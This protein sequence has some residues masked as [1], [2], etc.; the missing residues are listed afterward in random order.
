[1]DYP[2]T[3]HQFVVSR[4]LELVTMILQVCI[5]CHPLIRFIDII[6][7]ARLIMRSLSGGCQ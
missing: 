6:R 3:V 7:L 4:P 2:A 1:M 5:D